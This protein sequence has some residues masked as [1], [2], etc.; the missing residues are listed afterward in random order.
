[1]DDI[2]VHIPCCCIVPA[3]LHPN[4]ADFYFYGYL[5]VFLKSL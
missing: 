4:L 3:S 2:H 5:L 1:M